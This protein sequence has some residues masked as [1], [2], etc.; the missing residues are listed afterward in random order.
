MEGEG[1]IIGPKASSVR[2]RIVT[3]QFRES[4]KGP[5]IYEG[6][7]PFRVLL[8]STLKL[9]SPMGITEIA[10]ATIEGK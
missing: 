4:A 6:P 2:R 5:H 10:R 7:S 1:R 8:M 3:P 9:G